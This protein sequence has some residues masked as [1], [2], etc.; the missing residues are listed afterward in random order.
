MAVTFDVRKLAARYAGR[1]AVP[2]V[3]VVSGA[4]ANTNIA[5]KDRT[6]QNIR[7]ED[8][9]ANVVEFTAGVPSDITSTVKVTSDGNV[10]STES[11]SGNKLVI[12]WYKRRPGL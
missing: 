3:S 6:G 8:M 4:N 1:P 7:V 12:F 11:T 2:E 9:I 5:V 10:Q